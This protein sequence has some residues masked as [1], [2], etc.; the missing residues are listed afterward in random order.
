MQRQEEEFEQGGHIA[1]AF[2]WFQ[3][4]PVVWW[5]GHAAVKS[6]KAWRWWWACGRVWVV[7][8]GGVKGAGENAKGVRSGL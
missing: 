2:V 5:V 3:G 4:G 7:C 1:C 6:A 8:G